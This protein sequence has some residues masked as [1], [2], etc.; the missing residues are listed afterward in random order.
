VTGRRATIALVKRGW[1]AALVLAGLLSL[2]LA[3]GADYWRYVLAVLIALGCAGLGYYVCR[4]TVVRPT[5]QQAAERPD[6]DQAYQHLESLYEEVRG[7]C[8]A[9]EAELESQR[10]EPERL[11]RSLAQA[12]RPSRSQA[13]ARPAIVAKAGQAE[14]KGTGTP[15]A[16]TRLTGAEHDWSRRTGR[17]AGSDGDR[18][19]SE[20]GPDSGELVVRVRCYTVAGEGSS[21]EGS[22]RLGVERTV[23]TGPP[24]RFTEFF[25]Q[26]ETDQ[27]RNESP[28]DRLVD[29]VTDYCAEKITDPVFKVAT[30]RWE[31]RGSYPLITAA[32]GFT[33]SNDWLNELVERPLDE[34][35]GGIAIPA[36]A[37]S[38]VAGTGA[39]LILEPVA[40]PLT[41]ATEFCAAAGVLVGAAIGAPHLVAAGLKILAK[42]VMHRGVAEVG[43]G[44]FRE[45]GI[46]REPRVEGKRDVMRASDVAREI[47]SPPQRAASRVRP[48]VRGRDL[49]REPTR[50]GRATGRPSAGEIGRDVVARPPAPYPPR[51][52][53]GTPRGI[54]GIRAI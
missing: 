17:R 24:G 12:R 41:R 26:E 28:S 54:G 5:R 23:I 53:P 36:P 51:E 37:A 34:F 7:R 32:D 10:T 8:I 50:P 6:L 2:W 47:P 27:H 29:A 19:R 30:Q 1:L 16:G 40:K 43:K 14:A 15:R 21:A 18:A 25:C 11:Q 31:T 48:V 49:G 45:I 4:V 44:A 38:P 35:A 42:D 9:A 39:D 33:V 3:S 22:V 52:P 20:L 46:G 13:L